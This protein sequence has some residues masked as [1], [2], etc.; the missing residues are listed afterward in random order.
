VVRANNYGE[1]QQLPFLG[2]VT[3]PPVLRWIRPAAIS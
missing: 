3:P 2:T 1:K